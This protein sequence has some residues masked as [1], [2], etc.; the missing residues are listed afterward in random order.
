[1]VNAKDLA[2]LSGAHFETY[3]PC[4]AFPKVKKEDQALRVR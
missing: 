4:A 3:Y 1:M 2:V